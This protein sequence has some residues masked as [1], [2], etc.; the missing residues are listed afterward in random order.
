MGTLIATKLLP[1]MTWHVALP[2]AA[3]TNYFQTDKKIRMYP[4]QQICFQEVTGEVPPFS[5]LINLHRFHDGQEG[6]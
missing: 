2:K 4:A 6:G 1:L 3:A 5:V